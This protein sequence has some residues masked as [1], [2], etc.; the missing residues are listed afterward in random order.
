MQS[1]CSN[2][3]GQGTTHTSC[4]T[5]S[6]TGAVYTSAKETIAI[7]KGV[8]SGVNLRLS[9]KGNYSAK[10]EPGDLLIKVN[11]RPDP[12]FKR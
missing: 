10:V 9:K 2:C 7:P 6:G 1:M 11:V 8:D 3:H 4:L 5:C 12:Y